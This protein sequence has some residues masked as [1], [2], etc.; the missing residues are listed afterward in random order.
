MLMRLGI[1]G[2]TINRPETRTVD[3]AIE[4]AKP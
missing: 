3:R 1:G 4:K 2:I